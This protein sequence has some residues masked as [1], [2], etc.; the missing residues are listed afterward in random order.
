M[1]DPNALPPAT[2]AGSGDANGAAEAAAAAAGGERVVHPIVQG[3]I[4]DWDVLEACL[5][6]ALYD[7]VRSLGVGDGCLQDGCCRSLGAVFLAEL[8]HSSSLACNYG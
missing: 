7:R 2:P 5:D 3:T 6:H 8:L 4:I 1:R